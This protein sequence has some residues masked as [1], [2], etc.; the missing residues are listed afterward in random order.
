MNVDSLMI[1][2]IS[3]LYKSVGWTHYT[4]DTA[5]LEK[6]FEQSESLIKRNGE[7]KIIGVVRWITDCATIAFIQDILI[8]PR[9]Q[10]QGIGK[11]LLNEVLEKITSYGPVQIE[12][13]TDDTE[14][15]KKFYESVGFVP[16][17]EMDA[18][19]YI[20]DTRR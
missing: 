18:V 4:K 3:E 8:H 7:G 13:L 5:R 19:S 20:K 16:V 14:K 6:A 2:E 12:L 9:Y 1:D 15:T 17:K 11:A 10:R